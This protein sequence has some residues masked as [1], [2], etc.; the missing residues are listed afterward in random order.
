MPEGTA[1]AAPAAPSSPAPSAPAPAAAPSVPATPAPTPTLAPAATETPAAPPVATE[2]PITPAETPAAPAASAEPK[3]SDFEGD[4]VGFLEAHNEWERKQNGE[5]PT[6]E[7]VPAIEEKPAAEEPVAAEET[8]AEEKPWAPAPEETLT[9][10]AFNTL[11]KAKPEREQFLEADPELKNAM[12]AMARTNAKAAPLLEIFPNKESAEFAAQAAGTVVNLRSTFMEAADNPEQFPNAYAQFADEFAIK[13][14]DGKPVLDSEGNPTFGDDFHML[15]DYIVD[16]YHD[17]EIQDLEAQLESG[18]FTSDA[19]R[20]NADMALQALKFIKSWKAGESGMEKPDLSGL[21]D[22]VKAYYEGKERE[23]AE[24]EAALGGKEKNQNAE[25]RKQERTTY[26]KSVATKVGASVGS[27][28]KNM[29]DEREKSGVF[30][31]SYILEA[32][33]PATGISVFA[34]TLLDQFEE[35]TYGRTDKATGKIIGGVAFIRDQAKMLARRP[36]SPEAEQDR[37]DFANRLIDEHLPAIFDKQLREIQKRE[38]ADRG[39]RKVNVEARNELAQREPR[40]GGGVGTQKPV[41]AQDAMTQAYAW[42]DSQFPDISPSE[43]TEKALIK[44]NE[45]MGNR[46]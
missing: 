12:F 5:E 16:T 45:M 27:R 18:Q 31:P 39:R 28:L 46:Y 36:P 34:K 6:P 40:A 14:K 4:I 32:K 38:I 37:V 10:E 33:D 13:D 9:P 24:R 1:V 11:L 7:P 3:Q 15:N 35:A 21:P 19:Q 22:N 23:I 25:Q 44:K 26:E 29:L 2:T 43:R 8:P 30:I 17:V 41:S 20:E 42:V